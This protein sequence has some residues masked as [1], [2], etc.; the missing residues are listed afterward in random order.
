MFLLDT[1]VCI[2]FL[3]GR[4]SSLLQKFNSVPT[5]EKCLC[6]VVAGELLYGA[7]K[8]LR[9]QE[10][11]NQLLPFMSCFRM[12]D[13]DL[14]AAHQF[15]EIRTELERIGRP[16]GPFD[17]QIAAIARAT[18]DLILYIL[19]FIP[20]VFALT[21]A[22]YAFAVDSWVMNEHSSITADGP[23]IYPF[24]TILPLAGAFLLLQG[25][26]EIIRC[27]ICIQQGAWPSR[28]HDV[29]EVDVDKLKEM[30]HVKDEDIAKLDQFVVLQA[31][32]N[33]STK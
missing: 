1:N 11:L 33:G 6:S 25:V 8:S 3:Q 26:V 18:I 22:G 32:T 10:T 19:F 17:L 12:F 14:A 24:K 2:R 27:A 4:S 16:I 15:G 30:V 31:S 21:Y 20:G 29:E 7:A 9:K 23:P 13:F 5:D 28:E